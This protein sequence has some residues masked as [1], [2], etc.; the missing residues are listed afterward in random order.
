MDVN[1]W[2]QSGNF[3]RKISSKAIEYTKIT[4]HI[5]RYK[6]QFIRQLSRMIRPKI[7]ENQ[8]KKT[9]KL[10]KIQ[11]VYFSQTPLF[12]GTFISFIA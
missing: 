2:Q 1:Q 4:Y 5:K 7:I 8:I 12:I 11:K 9:M 10:R 6:T 3:E